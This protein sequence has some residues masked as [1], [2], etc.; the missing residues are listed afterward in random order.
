MHSPSLKNENTAVPETFN[1]SRGQFLST[2]KELATFDNLL[3]AYHCAIKGKKT[4]LKV[5]KYADN[6]GE[7]LLKLQK[8]ILNG[9]YSPKPC[10]TFEIFCTSGQKVRQISAPRFEDTIVQHLIYQNIYYH[11]DSKF[12]FDSYGCRRGKGMHKAADRLQDFIRKSDQNS[13]V[14]QLD[15][16]KYYY[17]INHSVLRDILC[18]FV[19]DEK[20]VGTMMDFCKNKNNIGLNVGCLLSQLFGLIYLNRFDHWI[21]RTLKIKHYIR[22]VDD[23]VFILPNKTTAEEVLKKCKEFLKTELCL[24]LS[25][26]KISPIKNSINFVGFR[27][28]RKG[29]RIRRRSVVSFKRALKKRK[30][31]SLISI[32]GHAIKT[33]DFYRCITTINNTMSEDEKRKFPT[34]FQKYFR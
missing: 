25:K 10:Y 23:M 12:I 8:R 6:L 9:T 34:S 1:P 4:R 5:F 16:R 27:T 22:Y 32:L 17:N 26:Y 20:L 19:R 14:L 30:F 24:E 13:Y 33:R 21:K 28:N 31:N 7:N 11:F 29:R 18:R 15:I 3:Y 2:L